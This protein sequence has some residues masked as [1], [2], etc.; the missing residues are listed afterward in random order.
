MADSERGMGV[1]PVGIL[2]P[3]PPSG[4]AKY[5]DN[6]S[7]R[8]ALHAV[9]QELLDKLTRLCDA[10]PTMAPDLIRFAVELFDAGIELGHD[11]AIDEIAEG[12]S[13]DRT[14]TEGLATLMRRYGL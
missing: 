13:R 10:S 4:A 3:G 11:D 5:T 1:F 8:I 14:K 2:R 9:P 7:D 6:L 12:R